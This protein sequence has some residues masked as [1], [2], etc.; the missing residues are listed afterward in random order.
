MIERKSSFEFLEITEQAIYNA[1]KI[2]LKFEKKKIKTWYKSQN[3]PVTEAD[4]EINDYLKNFFKTKT[5]D[6]G[7]LSEE[8]V[9]D[10]SRYSKNYFWCLDPID[11]TRSFIN[12]KPEYTIS[13]ALML[14]SSPIFGIIYNPKTN[15]MFSAK[16]KLGAFCNKQRIS[17]ENKEFNKSNI[18]LS[19]SEYKIIE[20]YERLKN[21]KVI[22]MGS[23][24]YKI[25]L[26]AKG[27]VDIAISFTKKN[28]WDLA[29]ATIILEEAGGILSLINGEQIN[30]NTK[31]LNIASVV[32]SNKINHKNLVSKI[33]L[34]KV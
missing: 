33:L 19:N 31:D 17:V 29:A 10:N 11:G 3:Q 14:N 15:E 28:D 6:F 13:L 8:S 1:G 12:G 22:K 26:V 20:K 30:Y 23:I 9:D 16:K 21:L 5:P 7:W 32:A 27:E 18:A 25:A 24:A 2:A 4:I 34:Q